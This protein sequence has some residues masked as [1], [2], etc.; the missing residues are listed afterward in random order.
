MLTL[1]G[2]G[3]G[4]G[5]SDPSYI[6]A[7][8]GQSF[9]VVDDSVSY[10]DSILSGDAHL[11][12]IPVTSGYR[13]RVNLDTLAGDSDLYLYY[14]YTLSNLSLLGFSDFPDL[15]TDN[16]SFYSDFNGYIY[17]EV[18][19]AVKGEYFISVDQL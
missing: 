6:I 3:G 13:Y 19:G 7:P 4:E 11:Y 8:N 10:H 2:C 9:T 18:Y 17:V 1:V 14:D 12:A 5:H 16:V 15:D